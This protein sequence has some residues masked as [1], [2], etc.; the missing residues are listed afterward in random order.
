MTVAPENGR[1]SSPK[2]GGL[3]KAVILML[4]SVAVI[5]AG[6]RGLHLSSGPYVEELRYLEALEQKRDVFEG[7]FLNGLS[8]QEGPGVLLRQSFDSYED[9]FT[10]LESMHGWPA[11]MFEATRELSGAQA[12]LDV[13]ARDLNG[14]DPAIDLRGLIPHVV[15]LHEIVENVYHKA[16]ELK[17]NTSGQPSWPHIALLA[18]GAMMLGAGVAQAG[19]LRRGG[20]SDGAAAGAGH[21]MGALR[22]QKAALEASADG[23]FIADRNGLLEYLNPSVNRLFG[24][25]ADTD[26]N[27][28]LGLPWYVLLPLDRQMEMQ[29]LMQPAIEQRGF[30]H[31]E[32]SIEA[33][34][35]F[36]DMERTLDI[37][38]SRLP[39]SGGDTGGFI[40]IVRDISDRK[41]AEKET[42][43]LRKQFFQAQK[44]ESIGRMAGGIAHDFNNILSSILGYAEFLEEDLVQDSAEQGFARKITEAAKQA[45]SLINQILSF[46]RKNKA[47]KTQTDLV[48]LARA[49]HDLMRSSVAR[50]MELTLKTEID[51]AP[52]LANATEISQVMMN[53][54]VNARDAMEDVDGKL[55]I[56]VSSAVLS[57]HDVA[58]LSPQNAEEGKR[59]KTRIEHV[60]DIRSLV[61]IGEYDASREYVAV[62]IQDN[63]TGILP[64]IVE[65]IFEPF[66]TTKDQDK[67]TGL[68]LSSVLGIVTG[69][70][71]MLKLDSTVGKGS[72]FTLY[73][74][75]V[76]AQTARHGQQEHPTA[77]DAMEG[78]TEGVAAPRRILM[79]D[80]D[81][82]VR[83]TMGILLHRLGYEVTDFADPLEAL[84]AVEGGL[85]F[86]VLVTDYMMPHMK[87]GE[88]AVRV[89]ELRPGTP[90]IIVSG[91][92]EEAFEDNIDYYP[93]IKAM[94]HKPVEKDVLAATL[95]ALWTS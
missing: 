82:F 69:H 11:A 30:W 93:F 70:D 67:G 16:S 73:F 53:L 89:H 4:C 32:L 6:G 86:D 50:E 45:R 87:G 44:M 66:F 9:E 68:G 5:T 12:H 39:D 17:E 49:T 79:V 27:G 8:A 80:D 38:V 21:A 46:S 48:D 71:G 14:D 85:T 63:G 94:M 72:V 90:V 91:F 26:G 19:Y 22:R 1:A 75:L 78:D 37:A 52:I 64:A 41:A 62:G 84:A 92:A 3:N 58:R 34:G 15:G 36:V 31:G 83:G 57:A 40:G 55:S 81:D 43:E 65:Q 2:Q 95:N 28:P 56:V 51:A 88:L 77:M 13:I 20:H 74:P 61:Y 54:C 47:G 25:G 23:I 33:Q 42:E 76:G 7:A 18:L 60:S 35:Q 10:R 24:V 59:L 29:R